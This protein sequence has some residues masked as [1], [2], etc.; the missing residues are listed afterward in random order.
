MQIR[1]RNVPIRLCLD[2]PNLLMMC[3]MHAENHT[4]VILILNLIRF[5]LSNCFFFLIPD[6]LFLV[7]AFLTPYQIIRHIA[8]TCNKEFV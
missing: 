2:S 4:L 6:D 7:F 5:G 8:T 3:S 1:L